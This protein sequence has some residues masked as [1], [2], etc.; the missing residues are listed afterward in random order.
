MSIREEAAARRARRMQAA[1][2]PGQRPEDILVPSAWVDLAVSVKD[3]MSEATRSFIEKRVEAVVAAGR[4]VW[5]LADPS[6]YAERPAF[7]GF[8]KDGELSAFQVACA[9]GKRGKEV[10]LAMYDFEEGAHSAWSEIFA[11]LCADNEQASL[12]VLR[13]AADAALARAEVEVERAAAIG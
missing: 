2:N 5:Y 9:T 1:Q 12:A 11:Y 6:F 4:E 3:A 10:V 7:G 8:R 13:T